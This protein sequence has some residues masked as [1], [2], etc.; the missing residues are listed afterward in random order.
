MELD[1]RG[2]VPVWW[3]TNGGSEVGEK[4]QGVKAVL[5]SGLSGARTAGKTRSHGDSGRR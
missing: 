5:L 4:L 1:H 2:G 3:L